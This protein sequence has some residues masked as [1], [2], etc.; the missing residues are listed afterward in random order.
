MV[1]KWVCPFGALRLFV[2]CLTL[3]TLKPHLKAVGN[4]FCWRVLGKMTDYCLDM[5]FRIWREGKILEIIFLQV[6][7]HG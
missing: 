5:L 1:S 3:M 4:I 7:F 6:E 2:N